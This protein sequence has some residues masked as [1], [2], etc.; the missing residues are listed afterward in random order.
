M[1][2]RLMAAEEL[3]ERLGVSP[4]TIVGWAKAGVIPEIRPSPRIGRFDY[5][6][7]VMVL[8]QQGQEAQDDGG[9]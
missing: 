8:K 9:H 6:D 7:V 4:S 1:S 5:E 2:G 3:A